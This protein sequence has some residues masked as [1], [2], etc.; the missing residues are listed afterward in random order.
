M[1]CRSNC[2][3][4]VLDVFE[5]L[6]LGDQVSVLVAWGMGAAEPRLSF[7]VQLPSPTPNSRLHYATKF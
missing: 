1:A 6:R 5:C 3:L 7:E 2:S 4:E